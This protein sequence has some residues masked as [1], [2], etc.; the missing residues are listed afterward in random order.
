MAY[1]SMAEGLLADPAD[2]MD[3]LNRRCKASLLR[4]DQAI[5]ELEQRLGEMRK[6]REEVLA[7]MTRNTAAHTDWLAVREGAEQLGLLESSTEPTRLWVVPDEEPPPSRDG[8]GTPASTPMLQPEGTPGQDGALMSA[9]GFAP[10]NPSV[11]TAPAQPDPVLVRG[12]RRHE[13]LNLIGSKPHTTWSVVDVGALL[14]IE[15][16]DEA[17]LHSVREVLRKLAILGALERIT[18]EG[19]IHA[20]YRPRGTWRFI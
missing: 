14:G 10:E 20:Y 11:A 15:K 4:Y 8:D 6:K 2:Q 12:A 3:L 9:A 5:P 18:I 13:V 19:D 7:L 16:E 17:G 1:E